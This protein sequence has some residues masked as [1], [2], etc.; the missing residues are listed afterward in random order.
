MNSF[1]KHLKDSYKLHKTTLNII[2]IFFIVSLF[3]TLFTWKL[4]SNILEK[5]T[6][7][8]FNRQVFDI[9]TLIENRLQLYITVLYG[10]QG[11]IENND[12]ISN[13]EWENYLRNL[14]LQNR[15]P[16]INNLYYAEKVIS[17]KQ[18]RFVTKYKDPLL[19]LVL[20]E[21]QQQILT[22]AKNKSDIVITN[23]INTESGNLT[24]VF[25]LLPIFK[26]SS[27]QGFILSEYLNNNLFKSVFGK[28]N[29]L[30]DLEVKLYAGESIDPENILYEN[31]PL[32]EIKA[33][34]Y[35]SVVPIELNFEK[36]T[37]EVTGEV[38]F[39]FPNNQKYF[40]VTIL[41]TGILVSFTLLFTFVF[42]FSRDILK[43]SKK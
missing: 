16:E 25:M 11:F 13:L 43:Y 7:S 18:D 1:F 35:R 6:K 21:A 4:T 29:T 40:P 31:V 41:V 24:G 19:T 36:L 2:F 38:G 23:K 37:L 12:K 33:S 39:G 22:R 34:K 9:Q 8:L 3:L 5:E 42:I 32:Q 14:Q 15:F 26:N 17:K 28:E 20:D 10:V 30:P 27:S